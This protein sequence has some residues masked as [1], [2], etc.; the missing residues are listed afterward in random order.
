MELMLVA[1]TGF[2]G[3]QVSAITRSKW[4]HIILLDSQG[5]VHEFDTQ[6]YFQ[7]PLSFYREFYEVASLGEYNDVSEEVYLGRISALVHQDYSYLYNLNYF[8]KE[9][10]Q[11]SFRFDGMNCVSFVVEVLQ[12]HKNMRYHAPSDFLELSGT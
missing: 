3:K 8:L 7:A 6:G 11:I 4:N 2:W 12:K 1:K 5:I 9:I 10:D